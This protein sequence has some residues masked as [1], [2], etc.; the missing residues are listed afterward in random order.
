M[1]DNKY[2]GCENEELNYVGNA[3]GKIQGCVRGIQNQ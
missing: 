2:I 3:G 1:H